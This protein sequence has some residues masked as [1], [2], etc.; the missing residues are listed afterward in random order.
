MMEEYLNKIQSPIWNIVDLSAM[1]QENGDV[2]G[3]LE[4]INIKRGLQEEQRTRLAQELAEARQQH[5]VIK[6]TR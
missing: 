4:E 2:T 5:E 6:N 3:S 1:E